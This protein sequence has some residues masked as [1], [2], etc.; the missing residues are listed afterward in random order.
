MRQGAGEHIPRALR[1]PLRMRNFA[2]PK[3]SRITMLKHEALS[4]RVRSE[5][6]IIILVSMKR[7]SFPKT[8]QLDI[9]LP[10]P[11]DF[12]MAEIYEQ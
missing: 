6:Q 8:R 2:L 5:E 10:G 12:S 3:L 7:T 1:R 4:S 11:C 9:D